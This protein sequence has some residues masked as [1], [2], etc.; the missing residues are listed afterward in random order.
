MKLAVTGLLAAVALVLYG[1][2]LAWA[3]LAFV[4]AGLAVGAASLQREVGGD[5]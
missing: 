5:K 1:L 3:P 2:W 4:A